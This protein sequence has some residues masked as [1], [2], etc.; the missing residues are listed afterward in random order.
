[1]YNVR[2]FKLKSTIVFLSTYP[3]RE[4]GIATFTQD[5]LQSTQN[6]LGPLLDCKVAALNLSPLDTYKYPPE[7]EW[8]IDQNSKL[9]HINLAKDINKDVNITGVIIQHEYGI[10]G[11]LEGEILLSFM[12]NCKKPMLVTLHT[13]LPNPNQ[14]MKT[15]TSEI[16]Q[17]ASTVVVLT[18]SSKNIIKTL[19]PQSAEKVFMIPHGIHPVTFS[20]P[21]KYKA[22]LKLDNQIILS[23]FGL[24]NRGKGIEYVLHALPKVIKRYPSILYLIL[25]ETH[26][27][28]RRREGE[29]YRVELAKLITKLDLKNHVRFY[30]QY[31]S[32]KD[33]FE[34]LKAT[35][36]YISTS[37]NPNQAVSGTLSYA[38]GTGRAVISTEFAQAKEIVTSKT[39]RLIPIKNS[40]ALS[41]SIID[42]LGNEKRLLKMH[43]QAYKQT[44][45]MLWNNVSRKYLALLERMVMPALKIDHLITMTDDF[46]L[47][48]FANLTVPNK[49]FGYTLDD[50]A[51]ALIVCSWLI[52]KEFTKK[53]EILIKIYLTFIKKCQLPD[54]SFVNYIGFSDK[55]P[56]SQNNIEDLEDSQTRA[57]WALSE[58]MANKIL[59]DDIRNQAKEMF[60][61]NFKL[62][63]KLTHLRSQ[64]FAIKS[65][66]LILQILPEKQ[67]ELLA[68]IKEHANS[69]LT[70]LTENSV[71]SWRWFES[72]LNYNNALLS[73]SLLI[74]GDIVKNPVY[75]SQG[76]LSLQF[77]IGKTFSKV[78]MPIGHAR[79]YKNKQKRSNYDQQPE[80][81]SSMIL[82]LSRAYKQ[83]GEQVYKNLANKCFSWF[84]GN[85]SLKKALYDVKSGGCYDG[86]HPDR[87]N[88][89]QGAESLIAYLMSSFTITHLNIDE[90]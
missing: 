14:K 85:N 84:L 55:L 82:A 7:V 51:R 31:F 48:Q 60:L 30:D 9:D 83:T 33:L 26:P 68:K 40:S 64:A 29:K 25:G 52:K 79:W 86:L 80:D 87:V 12:R 32:L 66:G 61:L 1:M 77:L 88:L 47:F 76:L 21:K 22:K 74:A 36:I 42:L 17:N 5:L 15:V 39:G 18:N 19:Y 3:P 37:T 53:L 10:F 73:E 34:F 65:F 28:V 62:K 63:T 4:C 16:I 6:F 89:N 43:H 27:V 75:T 49:D 78:Y 57:L 56:T 23:T 8:K 72:D 13:V 71:K 59:S 90:D 69:L 45:P 35:D 38:L 58:I 2:I 54:G 24:L 70:A 50:N 11:G 20:T 44:R 46:G 67:T 41:S 81:P